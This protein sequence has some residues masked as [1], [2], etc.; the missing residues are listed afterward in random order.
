[1]LGTAIT[2]SFMEIPTPKKARRLPADLTKCPKNRA[3]N[4]RSPAND[5]REC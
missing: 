2:F 1:M 5:R 4:P 3:A